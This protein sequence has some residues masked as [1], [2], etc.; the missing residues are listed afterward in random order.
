MSDIDT[1]IASVG[2]SDSDSGESHKVPAVDDVSVGQASAGD[3]NASQLSDTAQAMLDTVATGYDVLSAD[4]IG[5]VDCI[6]LNPQ[7]QV[8]L[9]I[10]CYVCCCVKDLL[11]FSLRSPHFT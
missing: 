7:K 9:C 8:C 6:S 3:G 5:C 10:C 4:N 2:R 1:P 11:T